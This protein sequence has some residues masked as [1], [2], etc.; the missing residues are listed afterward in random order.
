MPATDD[1]TALAQHFVG[2]V[3]PQ[4]YAHN[5]SSCLTLHFYGGDG[6]NSPIGVNGLD[7]MYNVLREFAG[8]PSNVQV[9]DGRQSLAGGWITD[10]TTVMDIRH[11]DGST[12]SYMLEYYR[13]SATSPW[14]VK[15]AQHSG[16]YH[17]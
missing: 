16:W 14:I 11:A 1:A 13:D 2:D 8:T 7:R 15:E 5:A 9:M 12:N 10:L 4:I 17:Q 6:P 3:L